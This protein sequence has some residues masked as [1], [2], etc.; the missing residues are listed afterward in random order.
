MENPRRIGVVGSGVSG[1]AAAY[2]LALSGH[3]V[4][5]LEKDDRFG[6]HTFTYSQNTSDEYPVD[7]GFQVFN[8][9]TYPYLVNSN[10]ICYDT[11]Y[12]VA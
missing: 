1:L 4:T 12:D 11:I 7:M 5:L 6:G 9:T 2:S 10:S 8:L 3:E